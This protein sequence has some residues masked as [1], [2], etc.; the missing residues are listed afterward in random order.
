MDVHEILTECQMWKGC[1]NRTKVQGQGASPHS[2][3]GSVG[4]SSP[5][6]WAVFLRGSLGR[7]CPSLRQQGQDT[8]DIAKDHFL[9]CV[10][11]ELKCQTLRV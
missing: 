8:R 10:F 9:F 4:T 6:C 5:K 11:A 1:E 2:H 3:E 7:G